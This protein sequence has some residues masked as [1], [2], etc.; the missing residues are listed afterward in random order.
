MEEN[1]NKNTW[2]GRRLGSGRPAL[3]KDEVKKIRTIK[4]SD[5][6]WQKIGELAEKKG[7]TKSEYIRLMAFDVDRINSNKL[8]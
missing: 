6:E 3:P 7:M 8:K 4:M 1:L 5:K 2:G